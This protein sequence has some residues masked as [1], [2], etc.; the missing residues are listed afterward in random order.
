MGLATVF[1]LV[2]HFLRRNRKYLSGRVEVLPLV[3][4]KLDPIIS[5]QESDIMRFVRSKTRI[6]VP[7][8]LL[9]T[10]DETRYYMLM[11]RAGGVSLECTWPTLT[12][13]QRNNVIEQLRSYIAQLRSIPHSHPGTICSI[14][15]GPCRD[16]R[17]AS[18]EA[19]GPFKD[20]AAFNDY[21]ID[22]AEMWMDPSMLPEIRSRMKNDHSIVFTHG[23]LAPRNI[24]VKGDRI[25]GI[26]DWENAGWYPEHWE[27]VKA[28]YHVGMN[29]EAKE[30]WMTALRRVFSKDYDYEW[31]LD[32]EL[33]DHMVGGF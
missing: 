24:M 26:I 29:G 19:F 17:V 6:P 25:T 11:T 3:V 4:I 30:S 16:G 22:V 10:K 15:F 31:H 14:D 28:L 12:P 2:L 32:R 13:S 18:A 23:D 27:Y 8:I 21:L 33:S 1:E 7:R 5:T 9:S 20:E